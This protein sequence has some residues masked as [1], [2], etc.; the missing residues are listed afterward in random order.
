MLKHRP[1]QNHY[2]FELEAGIAKHCLGVKIVDIAMI[3]SKSDLTFRRKVPYQIA[4]AHV[5]MHHNTPSRTLLN[6]LFALR[7]CT[8][9]RSPSSKFP[10]SESAYPYANCTCIARAQC[11]RSRNGMYHRIALIELHQ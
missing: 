11:I 2:D 7:R 6:S 5:H 10:E 8:K 9:F 3:K 4:R 1:D